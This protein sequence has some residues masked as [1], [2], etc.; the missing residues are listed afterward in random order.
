MQKSQIIFALACL[1]WAFSVGLGLYLL[2]KHEVSPGKPGQPPVKWPKDSKIKLSSDKD[3][4]VMFVHPQCPCT[5]ASIEQLSTLTNQK[6]LSIKILVLNPSLKPEDWDNNAI[7]QLVLAPAVKIE[8]DIDGLEAKRFGSETSGQT[9]LYDARGD[10]IFAG[11]I[12]GARGKT[13][14]N[15]GLIQLCTALKER[16]SPKV[17]Q[18][19]VFGCSLINNT[20][21]K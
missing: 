8:Q 15:Q 18:S 19:L 6:N 9:L 16:S 21:S 7:S 12:T 3:T 2:M 1:I 11:G 4:L 20:A 17:R 14:S 13:G 5:Q 10:L